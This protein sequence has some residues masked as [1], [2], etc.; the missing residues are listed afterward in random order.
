[1][2]YAVLS[3]PVINY[4]RRVYSLQ[5]EGKQIAARKLTVSTLVNIYVPTRRAVDRIKDLYCP[6][7]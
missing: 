7:S 3:W 2:I 1:M 6:N 4:V 5:S